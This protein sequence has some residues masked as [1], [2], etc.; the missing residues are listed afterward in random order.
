MPSPQQ[1]A[2]RSWSCSSVEATSTAATASSRTGAPTRTWCGCHRRRC[3]AFSLV[4]VSPSTLY[5]VLA[6]VGV[7]VDAVS[8]SRWCGCHRRRCIAFS[9]VWVSPSTLYRVLAGVG[10][11]VDAVSRSRWCGCHRRRCIAFSLVW[12]SPSTLYRVLAGVG[13]TV[14]AVS[15]SRWCGCHRRRCIA[16]SLVWVSPSTLYRVLAGDEGLF[17]PPARSAPR[18]RRGPCRT[19]SSGGAT[20][21][22]SMTSPTSSEPA[23]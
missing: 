8:R 9:L 4:W 16:F 1:S 2:G 17:C 23:G 11:T 20:R 5:R 18:R 3:I 7:T 22:G 19:G 15:R 14:D 12:V 13:V 10:V 21:S 6:G